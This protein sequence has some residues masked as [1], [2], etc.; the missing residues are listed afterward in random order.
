[1]FKLS[2][3]ITDRQELLNLGIIGLQLPRHIIQSALYNDRNSIQD[4][5]FTV[6]SDW[7]KQQKTRSEA[8][9]NI[10]G[11]LQKCKMKQLAT[12]LRQWV[13]GAVPTEISREGKFLKFVSSDLLQDSA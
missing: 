10:T 1:M 2:T 6:I 7:V 12:E 9:A 11:C 8:Y 3:R 13:E 5:A 4:A